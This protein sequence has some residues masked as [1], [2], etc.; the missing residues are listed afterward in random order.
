MLFLFF[1]LPLAALAQLRAQFSFGKM[2][3]R[4]LGAAADSE[5][6]LIWFAAT[7]AQRHV[8]AQHNLVL[9]LAL[10]SVADLQGYTAA[11]ELIDPPHTAMSEGVIA[12][13]KVL[14]LRCKDD[15][16]LSG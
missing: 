12:Q 3:E 9:A 10:A 13:A 8:E 14:A 6:A 15:P 7:A 2:H 4:G 5:Q 16:G 1:A 11:A